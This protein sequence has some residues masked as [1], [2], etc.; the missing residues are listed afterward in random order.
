MGP[1][2]VRSHVCPQNPTST[3]TRIKT[4]FAFAYKLG[5]VL[6]RTQLPLKQGLRLGGQVSFQ[7]FVPKHRTQ[8]PL[9][10]G[11]RQYFISWLYCSSTTQNPTSTPPA[12]AWACALVGQV[13][14][15]LRQ[16]PILRL[17]YTTHRTQIPRLNACNL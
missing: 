1:V 9:K 14:Q 5:P 2:L 6:H 8:L 11:L 13:K 12:I 17:C 7:S 10:Q 4:L 3:K 15:G 16:L